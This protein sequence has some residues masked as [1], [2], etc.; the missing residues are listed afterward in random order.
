MFDNTG[1]GVEVLS[2]GFHN[3]LSVCNNLDSTENVVVIGV[4]G[5][6]IIPFVCCVV[7]INKGF[8]ICIKSAFEVNW[9]L[10]SSI[11]CSLVL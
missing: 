6:V 3:G 4:V 11:L 9:N 2:T 10:V 1:L 7:G 5:E 8:L